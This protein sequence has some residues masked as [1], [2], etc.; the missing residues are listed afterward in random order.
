MTGKAKVIPLAQH[1]RAKEPVGKDR[2]AARGTVD[3]P[4]LLLT[5]LLTGIGLVMLFS[6]SFPA[7]YYTMLC[8]FYIIICCLNQSQKDVLHILS[9]VPRLSYGSSICNGKGNIKDLRQS[10]CQQ[11]L[12]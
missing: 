3:M 1:H 5:L 10:L 8:F 9:H 4:F 7:A 12:A 2:E 11:S 6:A